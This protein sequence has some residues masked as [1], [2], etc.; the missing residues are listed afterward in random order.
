MRFSSAAF[1]VSSGSGPAS[2]SS[3]SAPSAWLI[4]A[5]VLPPW[6]ECASSMMMAKV[7]PLSVAIS[8]RMKGNFCTVETMIFLPS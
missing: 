5:E 1:T 8:S 4:A 7:L 3:P 6:L 2:S